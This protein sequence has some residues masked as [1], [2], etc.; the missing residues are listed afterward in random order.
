MK[1]GAADRRLEQAS[2]PV[3]DVHVQPDVEEVEVEEAA[4]Q[5]PVVLVVDLDERS[6]QQAV[7]ED[8][9]PVT[10]TSPVSVNALDPS[11]RN[12][13]TLIAISASVTS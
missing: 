1:R 6:V 11:A 10:L 13:I 7:V 5:Q 2:D 4:R 3:E 12:T 9:Q 8:A